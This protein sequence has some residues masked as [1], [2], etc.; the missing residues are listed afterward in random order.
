MT[1][2]WYPLPLPCKFEVNNSNELGI[3]ATATEL[4]LSR[5]PNLGLAVSIVA[6]TTKKNAS[7]PVAGTEVI[8]AAVSL[9]TR[10]RQEV[11]LRGFLAGPSQRG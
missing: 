5:K 7:T 11:M 6:P 9:R 10:A 3:D 4:E 2:E 8:R 1:I